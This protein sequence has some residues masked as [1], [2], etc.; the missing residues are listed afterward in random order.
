MGS[1]GDFSGGTFLSLQLYHFTPLHALL[2]GLLCGIAALMRVALKGEVLGISGILK[3]LVQGAVLEPQRWCF[4]LGMLLCSAALQ[5]VYPV[6]FVEIETPVALQLLGGLLV[7]TGAALGN[8]CTSG[9]GICGNA[10]LSPR[11]MVYTVTFMLA[12]FLTATLAHSTDVVTVLP[13]GPEVTL[14]DT[15]TIAL[16][17]LA[18][19]LLLYVLS[20]ALAPERVAALATDVLDGSLFA[21]GLGLSGMTD[22]GKVVEFLDLHERSWNPTLMFVMGGALGVMAPFMLLVVRPGRLAAPVLA[23]KFKLP[24]RTDLEPRLLVGGVLFGVGWGLAGIC[25]GPSMVN[26]CNPYSSP[27]AYIAAMFSGFALIGALDR[28]TGQQCPAA[29]TTGSGSAVR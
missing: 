16:V 19:H 11:S 1:F 12:G 14:T 5:T 23:T 21:F 7:G 20:V 17:A 27:A 8:G 26:V 18:L 13:R 3:G 6:A 25:P 10:R 22:P 15:V 2:G 9:H 4:A 29:A 24:T 28:Y